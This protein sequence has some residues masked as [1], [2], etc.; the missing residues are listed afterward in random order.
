M[1]VLKSQLTFHLKMF[2]LHLIII[3]NW[4]KKSR[5][6]FKS[7]QLQQQTYNPMNINF[8]RNTLIPLYF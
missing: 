8:G 1:H 6:D 7:G 4:A 3:S 2:N 5:P